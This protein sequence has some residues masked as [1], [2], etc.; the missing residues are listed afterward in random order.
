MLEG[1]ADSHDS[2]FIPSSYA[3]EGEQPPLDFENFNENNTPQTLLL[4]L[5]SPGL[6]LEPKD[7]LNG[8]MEAYSRLDM[9]PDLKLHSGDSAPESLDLNRV[10]EEYNIEPVNS[11]MDPDSFDVIPGSYGYTFDL[12]KARRMLDEAHYGDTI[13][14]PMEYVTPDILEDEVF[15]RDVLSTVSTPHGTNKKRNVNLRLA[16]E[17]IN[18][19]VLNPGD[20]FSYNATLG[21]RTAE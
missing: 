16:C 12:Q 11:S 1:Y 9:E 3:L 21:Q 7:A 6:H 14:I 10:F 13:R 2:T 20:E 5:G 18:G 15:F 4:I 19:L 8:I 17:A